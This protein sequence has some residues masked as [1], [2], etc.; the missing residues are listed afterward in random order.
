MRAGPTQRIQKSAPSAFGLQLSRTLLSPCTMAIVYPSN[1]CGAKRRPEVKK[2]SPQI[3]T[4]NG[5]I[6]YTIPR[7]PRVPPQ[8]SNRPSNGGSGSNVS[9]R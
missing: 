5:P 4:H 6:V 2:S 8:L 1:D 9:E 7:R 3:T